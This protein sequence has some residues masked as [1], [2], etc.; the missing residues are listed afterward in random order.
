MNTEQ[1]LAIAIEAL[2]QYA[3]TKNWDQSEQGIQRI[4][5]EPNSA[6]PEQYHG[7]RTAVVALLVIAD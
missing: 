3:N 4:W 1:K 5:L 6:I 7:Y 2:E